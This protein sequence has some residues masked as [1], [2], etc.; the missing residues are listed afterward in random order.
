MLTTIRWYGRDNKELGIAK[1]KR[2][3]KNKIDR[4]SVA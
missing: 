2:K 3:E 1:K 4:W